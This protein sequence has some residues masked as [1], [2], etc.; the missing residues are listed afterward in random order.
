ME[1]TAEAVTTPIPTARA[2]E[3]SSPLNIAEPRVALLKEV[4][5][6]TVLQLLIVLPSHSDPTHTPSQIT[7][8]KN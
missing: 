8:I 6:K 5:A 3:K 2:L 4:S 7:V 1:H